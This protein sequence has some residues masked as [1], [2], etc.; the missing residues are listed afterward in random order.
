MT[1]FP[2]SLNKRHGLH[3]H[4]S[5]IESSSDDPLEFC[6]KTG[7]HFNPT[8]ETHGDFSNSKS[9]HLGDYGNVES[10]D[11]A[12]VA[13][14]EDETNKLLGPNSIIGRSVV[15]HKDEDDLGL[16]GDKGSKT[17]GNSGKYFE[18]LTKYYLFI[19][20]FFKKLEGQE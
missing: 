6:S 16:I 1:G 7:P 17:S 5:S 19:H 20:L 15:L 8:N 18:K 3:I 2:V 14:L 11:G 4:W 9:R 12:I 10:K 13:N